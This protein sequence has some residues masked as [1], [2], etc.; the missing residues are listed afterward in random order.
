[1]T[2]NLVA[3]AIFPLALAYSGITAPF[4]GA[5]EYNHFFRAYHV[6]IGGLVA[7]HAAFGV[8]GEE[9]PVS[10][11]TLARAAADFPRLPSIGSSAAQF[12]AARRIPLDPDR[13]AIIN[14]PNCALYSPLVYAPAA[15]G[16]AFGRLLGLHPLWLFYLARCFSA[17]T[18]ASLLAVAIKRLPPP[19]E[20]FAIL[21]LVPMAVFQTAM[22]SADGFTIA[23][24]LL[25]TAEILRLRFDR[26]EIARLS[27]WKLLLLALLLSQLRPPYPLIGLAIFALPR[28]SFRDRGVA[29]SFLGLFL[30]LLVVPCFLWNWMAAGL[31]SQMRPDVVT[32]PHR[33]LAL[34]LQSPSHF[35]GVLHLEFIKHGAVHLRELIGYFGWRNFPLPWPLIIVVAAALLVSACAVDVPALRINLTMRLCFLALATV[36][37]I[38]VALVIYLTWDAVGANDVGGLHGRYFLPFLPFAMVSIANGILKNIRWCW[39]VAFITCLL[40]NLIALGLLAGATFS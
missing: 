18:V 36:G 25:F 12:R 33:Q 31:F 6:S 28:E 4:R 29:Y 26:R 10:L 13:T 1:M 24:G 17:L 34:I 11:L 15:G 30:L 5:D 21:P 8:V 35:L 19:A 20:S 2:K 22:I 37:I 40:S 39:P 38:G 32:D 16:I 3:F 27:R 14:F 9:L 23:L 7:H